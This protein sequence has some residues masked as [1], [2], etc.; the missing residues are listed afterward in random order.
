L[1]GKGIGKFNAS[2]ER[3]GTITNVFENILNLL[4]KDKIENYKR[5]VY[6]A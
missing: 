1:V 6:T 4:S 3:A 2:D 5:R